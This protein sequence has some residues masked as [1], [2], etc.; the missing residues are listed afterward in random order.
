MGHVVERDAQFPFIQHAQQ[1]QLDAQRAIVEE[2]RA[3]LDEGQAELDDQAARL[4]RGADHQEIT[5]VR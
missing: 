5:H 4:E 2:Q 1:A 3:Q